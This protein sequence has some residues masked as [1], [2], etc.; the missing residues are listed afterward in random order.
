MDLRLVASRYYVAR[1][2]VDIVAAIS[3]HIDSMVTIQH[4][5]IGRCLEAGFL[6]RRKGLNQ[7]IRGKLLEGG[8]LGGTERT[9]GMERLQW[10]LVDHLGAAKLSA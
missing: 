2:C 5:S 4:R 9:F 8:E 1:Q 10:R 3:T 7:V 6:T